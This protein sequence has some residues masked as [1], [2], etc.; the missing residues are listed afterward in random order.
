MV[1]LVKLLKMA[2]V[3]DSGEMAK[4][5]LVKRIGQQLEEASVEDLLIKMKE[6]E[7]ESM[8]YDVNIVQEIVKEFIVQDHNGEFEDEGQEMGGILSEASKLMVV[9]LVDSYLTEISKDPNLPLGMFVDLAEMV[10]GFSR[11]SH[12]GLYRA[13][14]MYLKTH[15]G[16]TKSERKRICKLMDCKKLSVDAC[17]HA[18]QNERLPLRVTV[19]VLF[20]EQARAA[21]SSG[22]STPDLPKS[23]KALNVSSHGRPATNQEDDWDGVATAEEL[24]ALKEELAAL[25]MSHHGHKN[26][27]SDKAS[28]PRVK[29]L[30]STKKLLSKIWSSKGGIKENSGSDS[31]ESLGSANP[32]DSKSTPSRKGR[33]LVS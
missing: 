29:G 19:Q 18:V 6:G 17:M 10:N 1:F 12:D 14:D 30:L 25:R 4:R 33:Y 32:D 11:P 22:S 23:I 3:V 7:S 31:S 26:T 27:V 24:K 13:I 21:T 2:I 20:F 8:I 5:E 16:I 15:Q 9:K 28:V